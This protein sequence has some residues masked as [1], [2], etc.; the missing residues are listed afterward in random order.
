MKHMY[1]VTR[2]AW[3]HLEGWETGMIFVVGV[4]I[5]SYTFFHEKLSVM[6]EHWIEKSTVAFIFFIIETD[7]PSS[8]QP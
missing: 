8:K 7:R 6:L 1:R 2:P 4:A 3:A 5:A